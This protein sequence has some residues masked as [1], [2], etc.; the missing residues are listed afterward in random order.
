MAAM[1]WVV[2]AECTVRGVNVIA[3]TVVSLDING[4]LAAE[5]GGAGNLAPL[6]AD[7]SGDAADH[8]GISN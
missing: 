8:S 2:Q 1:P 5:Y 7:Q 6:P 4:E 3:G